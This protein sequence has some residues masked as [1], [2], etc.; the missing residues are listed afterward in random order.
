MLCLIRN[1]IDA[2]VPSASLSGRNVGQTAGLRQS[3]DREK[4]LEI[5]SMVLRQLD[6]Y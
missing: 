5:A 3:K 6:R 4:L 1:L 2:D